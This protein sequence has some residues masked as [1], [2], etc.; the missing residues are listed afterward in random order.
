[1]ID[2]K[3]AVIGGG[4]AGMIAAIT[5]AEYGQSVCLFEATQRVGNKILMTGNGKCNFSN[6]YMEPSCYYT[7]DLTFVERALSSF[8]VN[9]SIHFFEKNGMLIRN[10]NG[11]LYPAGE[12][13]SIVLDILRLALKETDVLVQTE[14]RVSDILVCKDKPGFLLKVNE[15]QSFFEKVIVATGGKTYP[16]TGSDGQGLKMAASLG[17]GIHKTVPA[18]VQLIGTD[19]FYKGLS[20]VRT[21]GMLTLVIDGVVI[22]TERGEI[23]FTDYGIS[24]I[25]V[26]QISR[27]VCYALKEKKKVEMNVDFL[28]DFTKEDYEEF[29]NNRLLLHNQK[30]VE[31]FFTGIANKKIISTVIKESG[32]SVGKPV[33][34]VSKK[35]LQRVFSLLRKLTF[36]ISDSKKYDSAQVTAGG[37]LVGELKDTF[38]AKKFPGLYF[39]GEMVDVDGKCG[40]YNLQWAWTS[41]SIA[42]KSAAIAKNIVMEKNKVSK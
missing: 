33:G 19:T 15:K 12:Q 2:R 9:D 36:H 31:E 41:G 1:M 30:T 39:V 28:P 3:I 27:Q 23:Q 32:L 26:F 7:E 40:G 13:A 21:D 18:L 4:A 16:K 25:P 24:G 42:G 20:G 29:I 17:I 11:Y 8:S 5:A 35:E 10:K 38:E 37:V 22:G 34:E 6:L 14:S